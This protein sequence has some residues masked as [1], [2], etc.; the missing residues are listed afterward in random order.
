[1]ENLEEFTYK[2]SKFFEKCAVPIF[3]KPDAIT[4]V[5]KIICKE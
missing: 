1:M 4:I 3:D 2:C 5:E